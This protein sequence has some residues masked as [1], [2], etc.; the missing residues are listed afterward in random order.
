M[1]S[2][3]MEFY[4]RQTMPPLLNSMAPK[5]SMCL[6]NRLGRSIFP[7][8]AE[9]RKF[10]AIWNK[11]LCPEGVFQ[12]RPGQPGTV[13]FTLHRHHLLPLFQPSS[14]R[15]GRGGSLSWAQVKMERIFW[16]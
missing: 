10:R 1:E 11:E 3:I 8:L 12:H 16:T 14:D 6:P 5:M 2:I 4:L 13:P 9:V 7:P 15:K